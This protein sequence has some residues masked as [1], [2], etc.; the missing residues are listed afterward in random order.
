MKGKGGRA[1]R[2]GKEE[3]KMCSYTDA[4]VSISV[5]INRAALN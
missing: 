4:N 2:E 3:S 5:E 1:E